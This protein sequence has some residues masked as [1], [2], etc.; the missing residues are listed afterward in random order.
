MLRLLRTALPV[1]ALTFGVWGCSDDQE[2]L[3]SGLENSAETDPAN[4]GAGVDDLGTPGGAALDLSQAASEQNRISQYDPSPVYFA[5]DKS[6]VT[7]AAQDELD[8][9][10]GFLSDNQSA[11]VQ[12]EGHCDARGSVEYNIA[13][14]ERRAQSVKRYLTQ[15]GV[16]SARITTIS[17][18]EERPAVVGDGEAIWSQNRRAVFVISSN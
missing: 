3:D 5:F 8:R 13:L 15:R 4:P 6:L 18:G 14:G 17:Y 1:V 9:L 16:S 12:I 11:A 10:V 2:E 7:S